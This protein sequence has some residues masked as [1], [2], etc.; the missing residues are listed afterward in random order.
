MRTLTALFLA[1]LVFALISPAFSQDT[2]AENCQDPPQFNRL[3]T[4]YIRSCE[5]NDFNFFNF[6]IG[7]SSEEVKRI[8]GKYWMVDYYVKD[9][10]KASTPLAEIRNYQA[11]IQKAGGKIVYLD[12]SD[13][14]R[15]T[16]MFTKDG[17]ETWMY[18]SPRD[19]GSGLTVTVVQQEAMKQE[20]TSSA[21]MDS[22][23]AT[24]HI[25]LAINFDTGKSTIKDDSKPIVDQM[26][27]LMK[28]NPDLKV[29][30]QGHT[31]NVGKADANKK[32]SQD[33]AD[34]VKKALTDAGIAAARM[35]AMGYGDTK[36]VASND[37]DE[38]KAKNRRVE[39]VKR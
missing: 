9:G 29:E 16:G 3:P 2:D 14:M 33:R 5:V 39:L 8:E 17:A 19:L 6:P 24:G 25:S 22:L 34:A 11:A 13:L 4:Y 35:T 36:P 10:Q 30:I 21:M 28:S 15:V 37:T 32:L 1:S 12:D 26:I 23:K 27:D 18:V 20:I 38:G 31:D 7:K